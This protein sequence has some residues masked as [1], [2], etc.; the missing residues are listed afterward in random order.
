M[1]PSHDSTW[2][3][4]ANVGTGLSFWQRLKNFWMLW[5]WI[6]V[7]LRDLYPRHQQLAEKYFGTSLPQ[8]VD[9]MRNTSLI[10]VNEDPIMSYARPNLPNIIRFNS[11][12]VSKKPELLPQDLKKFINDATDG[13]IY[14]C[15]G[16]NARFTDLPER[17]Q[18]IFY[19]VFAKL[20]YKVVWKLEKPPLRKLDNVYVSSWFPQ[21]SVLAHRN[22]RLYMYQGGLQ[23]T[24]EAIHHSVP[25]LGF[26]VL[27]DQEFQL[28]K[29]KSRGIGNRLDFENL[30]RDELESTILEM[31]TNQ[32]YKENMIRVRNLLKDTP[33]DLMDH[34]VWWTEYV[35]RNNDVPHFRSTLAWEPWYHYCDMDVIA[36][37]SITS[38]IIVLFAFKICGKLLAWLLNK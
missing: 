3:M 33:Y 25:V 36:F 13:F 9:L 26:P 16:T 38:F 32:E 12:H 17:I 8:V 27:S 22:I 31:I 1:L 15:M 35:I 37:L 28:K 19:D 2:E 11:I 4:E 14:F 24:Q 10:F 23:S 21:Q 18:H 29:I 30:T 20:P 7:T 34:L 5:H 6:Y